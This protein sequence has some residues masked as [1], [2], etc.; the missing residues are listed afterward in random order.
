MVSGVV[1]AE[2]NKDV[3]MEAYEIATADAEER[4]QIKRKAAVIKRWQKLI[5]DL[6]IRKKLQVEYGN[7]AVS[8][9]PLLNKIVP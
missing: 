9:S 5:T 7:A 8:A 2:E 3:L 6:R 1:I 4:A